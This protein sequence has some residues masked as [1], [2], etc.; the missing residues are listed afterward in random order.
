MADRPASTGV[1]GRA[2]ALSEVDY[3]V[4]EKVRVRDRHSDP[5]VLVRRPTIL[6]LF[7]LHP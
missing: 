4:A 1:D 2:A 5:G 7:A 6:K 3:Q